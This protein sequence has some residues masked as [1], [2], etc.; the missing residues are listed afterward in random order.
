MTWL[1]IDLEVQN[2]EWY[3]SVA[4]PHCPDNFVVAA[5]WSIDGGAVQHE[6]F[7]TKQESIASTWFKDALQ[8]QRILVSHNSTFELHWLLHN[9]RAV[10]LDW[11]EQGGQVFCTQY[12]E[13]LLSNQTHQY[14][15]LEDLSVKYRDEGMSEY[16][17]RKLDEVKILWESGVLTAD[18]DKELLLSYLCDPVHGDIA[19]TRRVCF[20]QYAELKRRGMW[21]MF[22]ARMDSLLFNA[23]ATFNGLYVNQE[24][25]N[26]NLEIQLAAIE[27][28]Q[29]DILSQLPKDM[30]PELDF[31]FTSGYHQS[32][33]LFGGEIGYKK[34]VSYEPKKFE[35]VDAYEFKGNPDIF[36]PIED[37]PEH[38]EDFLNLTRYVSGKNKGKP[39]VFKIDSDVEKLKWGDFTYK[40]EGLLDLNKLPPHVAEQYTGKRAEFKGKRT[41]SC[42]TPVYSTSGDS[43]DIL[44][45]FTE[46]AKPLHQ[47][48]TLQKDTGTYYLMEKPNGKTSGMLQYV[49]PTSIIHHQLNNCATITSRLSSSKPNF[50]NLPRTDEDDEGNSKSKVK[51]MFTS[52]FGEE[53]R[54]VEVDFSALEV[55]DLAAVSGDTNLLRM[56]TEGIDMHCYRLAAKLKEPY[57][58]VKR[59]CKDVQEADHAR[60]NRMRTDIKPRAFAHQYGATAAGISY[61]TGCSLEEAE[62]FKA[63]EFKLFPE[64][65]AFPVEHVRPQVEA[66]GLAEL[67]EREFTEGIGWSLYRRGYYQAKSGTCYSFRQY[68]QW[69]EGQKVMDYKGTQIANYPIQGESALIVQA[70]CGLVIREFIKRGFFGGLVLPINT[71]HDA[72]YLDCATEAL[73]IEAGTLVRE[74]MEGT[75]KWLA[76]KIPALKDWSYHTTPFPAVAEYGRSMAEKIHIH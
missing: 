2:H 31:S 54:I 67:P 10:L 28:L 46:A 14:A 59:K 7:N 30:P 44:A 42:G 52:R 48:A 53:G 18:I 64:S 8:G 13:Y 34:K 19:N 76:E 68:E 75:P 50:Q 69:Q 29:T 71:V 37:S 17:V 45:K 72:I 32:A 12:S 11:I 3:G 5:G 41:L 16:D 27:E 43:L 56:L 47:L 33:L 23:I 40:F 24:I 1:V 26:K 70:A 36:T 55:V 38:L 73:A 4:S 63:I 15:K 49:E 57:E 74:I 22:Q 9:H 66:T 39:K 35:K 21:E 51:E 61:S 58:D 60:Y 65:N 25:A 62:E 6:Y 20:K